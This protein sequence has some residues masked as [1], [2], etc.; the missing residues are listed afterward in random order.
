MRLQNKVAVIT[1]ASKGLGKAVALR[2]AQE[3]AHVVL[4]SRNE[5]NLQAAAEEIRQQTG[6][7]NLLPVTVDVS[8]AED[9]TRLAD[10]IS[11]RFSAV[12]ILVNNAG[13]PP[14][15]RFLDFD[16]TAWQAAFDLNVMSVIRTTRALFPMLQKAGN[17]KIINCSSVVVDQPELDLTLSSTL[18]PAVSA[19]TKLLSQD[20]AQYGIR[21]NSLLP[22]RIETD[23]VRDLDR[24]KA[25]KTG[26]SVEQI[27]TS[28][29]RQIPLAR[30]GDPTEFAGAALF[31]ATDES[32]Y[33]TGQDL[34]IDGGFFKGY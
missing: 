20:F 19:L 17:A 29:T 25:E 6:S 22:G 34:L 11:Q 2:F 33:I 8:K 9:I 23:R 1:A 10:L 12:D 7:T 21:V 32:G 18:R 26:Q 28:F 24:F 16:D 3:G 13:G 5:A 15:G 27:K 31:L 14:A 4:T 30:Y